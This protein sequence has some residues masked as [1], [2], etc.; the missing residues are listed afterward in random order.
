M[1]KGNNQKLKLL[2]LAK[3]LLE[4]TDEEHGISMPNIIARLN[5]VDITADRKTIYSDME[6]L[7]KFGIDVIGAQREKSFLYYVASRDFELPELKLLVDSVQAARFI[8]EKKSNALIRKLEKLASTHE[9]KQL[10]RQVLISGRIKTMNESIYYNVDKIHTA[11]NA[12]SQIRFQYFQWN[13]NKEQELRHN[14][15]WYHVSPWYLIWDDEYYYLVA[16]DG[17]DKI[18]KHYRLDKMLRIALT[19]KEREGK[20]LLSSS[21]VAA[22]SKS[23][24]GMFGGEKVA[25]TLEAENQFAGILIDRFGKEILISKVD[26]GHFRTVVSVVPSKHFISWIM[27]FGNGIRIVAPDSVLESVRQL[28]ASLEKTYLG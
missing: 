11:I 23:L 6:E 10:Q 14:G 24:F 4:E 21:D 22:Y 19:N 1:A 20:E 18:L 28:L 7:R 3:I 26:D 17:G 5:E 15:K 12:N 16:Y 27:S 9:A 25:V 13:V 2:Y 8:T